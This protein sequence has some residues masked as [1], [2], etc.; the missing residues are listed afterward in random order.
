MYLIGRILCPW[1]EDTLT[2]TYGGLRWC[3]AQRY[4]AQDCAI[5]RE[6]LKQC[7]QKSLIQGLRYQGPRV[8]QVILMEVY[9]LKHV[10]HA[11]AVGTE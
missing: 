11:A 1:Q 7:D 5:G 10:S 6:E 9:D 2:I 4:G 3:P 8:W